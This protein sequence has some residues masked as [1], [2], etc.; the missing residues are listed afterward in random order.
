MTVCIATWLGGNNNKR[1]QQQQQQ[2]SSRSMIDDGGDRRDSVER[3]AIHFFMSQRIGWR[4][5][6]INLYS[7]LYKNISTNSY[8]IVD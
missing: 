1:E 6:L 8:W 7:F 3:R 2:W 4:A 5:T